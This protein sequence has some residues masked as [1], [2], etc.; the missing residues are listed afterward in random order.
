MLQ[1]FYM[2]Q[3]FKQFEAKVGTDKHDMDMFKRLF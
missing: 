2:L 1:R 3:S